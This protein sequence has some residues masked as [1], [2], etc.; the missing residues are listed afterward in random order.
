[1]GI[2]RKNPTPKARQQHYIGRLFTYTFDP[3][4]GPSFVLTTHA[5]EPVS[6]IFE[7]FSGFDYRVSLGVKQTAGPNE[8]L[9]LIDRDSQKRG[10]RKATES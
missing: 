6:A 8:L 5:Y 10:R 1:M 4:Q 9:K 2:R 3:N 7:Q